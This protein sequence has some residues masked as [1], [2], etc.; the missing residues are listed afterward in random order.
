[1]LRI[2]DDTDSNATFLRI[3]DVI[4]M[5]S[6][7][8]L[9]PNDGTTELRLFS[10]R[11]A[12]IRSLSRQGQGPGELGNLGGVYRSGDTLFVTEPAPRSPLLHIFTLGEGFRNRSVIRPSNAP[13]GVSVVGRLS[14]GELLVMTGFVIMQPVA[15]VLARDTMPVGI[16]R[17]GPTGTVEWL[18]NFPNISWLGY[19]SPALRS[20]VGMVRYTLGPS[21]VTGVSQDRVWI[22]DSGTGEITIRDATGTIVAKADLPVRAR[23]FSEA[24]LERAKQRALA[25]ATRPQDR[26]SHEALYASAHRPRRAPVFTRFIPANDGQMGVELFEE[27][28]RA[29]SRSVLMLDRNGIPRGQFVC[30]AGVVLHEIGVDYVLGVETDADDVER[31]VMYR[32]T[33]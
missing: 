32:L 8:I 2:G 11:G 18:G 16:L 22:G 4:R 30:P 12:F 15:G 7:D 3:K 33:R 28:D 31:V 21:L 14:G 25:A 17:G 19:P 26:A 10:P 6:G 24:S 5:P 9:V 29:V 13:K 23:A 1:M 20:G 27:E